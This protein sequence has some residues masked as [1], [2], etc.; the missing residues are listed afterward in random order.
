MQ[1][2]TIESSPL[3]AT[4]VVEA[5]VHAEEVL[6]SARR[7]AMPLVHTNIRYQPEAYL[8][9]GVWLKKAP[10]MKAMVDGNPYAAFCPETAP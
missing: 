5:Q 1:G 10:V 2:Y 4:G 3:Y 6:H 9:G 7:A 8:D